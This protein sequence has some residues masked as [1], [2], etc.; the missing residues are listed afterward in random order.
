MNKLQTQLLENYISE[1][2]DPHSWAVSREF[3]GDPD[4]SQKA[5]EGQA[6]VLKQIIKDSSGFAKITKNIADTY[7][8]RFKAFIKT[9]NRESLGIDNDLLSTAEKFMVTI[10]PEIMDAIMTANI[11]SYVSEWEKG[12]NGA[13]RLNIKKLVYAMPKKQKSLS[14]EFK[15]GY[16]YRIKAYKEQKTKKD[17][18]M[19]TEWSGDIEKIVIEKAL[20]H[21]DEK[22]SVAGGIKELFLSLMKDMNI[23]EYFKSLTFYTKQF[24]MSK[25]I[26]LF[27]I[28]AAVLGFT[29][30]FLMS[31][32]VLSSVAAASF[33]GPLIIGKKTVFIKMLLKIIRSKVI[34]VFSKDNIRKQLIELEL[35]DKGLDPDIDLDELY[36]VKYK[37]EHGG[38]V[39]RGGKFG[40]HLEDINYDSILRIDNPDDFTFDEKHFKFTD[41]ELRADEAL[42]EWIASYID[43]LK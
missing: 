7:F 20:S 41:E 42:R 25:S 28:Q 27:I 17:T 13:S 29:F 43:L 37:K 32:K 4:A 39:L 24:G 34:A 33:M 14:K 11:Q 12:F 31:K 2:M 21:Y 40:D 15:E 26:F 38:T 19:Y 8:E 35:Y 18:E 3:E 23:F 16:A 36:L 1:M 6:H 22:S 30:K 9:G 5:L 10:Y